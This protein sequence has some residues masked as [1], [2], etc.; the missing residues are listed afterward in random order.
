MT[1]YQA[2][3]ERSSDGTFWGCVPDLPG[4]AGAG[5]TLDEAKASLREAVRLWVETA[6]ERGIP[7]PPPTTVATDTIDVPAA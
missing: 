2:I 6:R 3:Y 5:E 4:T 7:I 1:T